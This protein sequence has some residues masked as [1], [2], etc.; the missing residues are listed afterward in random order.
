MNDFGY[1]EVPYYRVINKVKVKTKVDDDL[2]LY[3]NDVKV[4][5]TLN[6][7]LGWQYDRYFEANVSFDK[8]T[9]HIIAEELNTHGG[10]CA[11]NYL[12]IEF[13]HE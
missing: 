8:S 7:G 1:I 10:P 5:T 4:G 6:D 9:I 3:L 13:V 2:N 11:L 12:N